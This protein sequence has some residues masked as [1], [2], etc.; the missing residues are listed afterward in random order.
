MTRSEVGD[1]LDERAHEILWTTE[2]MLQTEFG[3]K[4]YGIV[5][6][7]NQTIY[8]DIETAPK[9]TVSI[10]LIGGDYKYTVSHNRNTSHI[11]DKMG[12]NLGDWYDRDELMRVLSGLYRKN[13][14]ISL[15]GGIR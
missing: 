11:L 1:M 10:A 7:A 2:Y 3:I 8:I 14:Q 4:T 5:S 13:E 9:T 6:Q 15:F 12:H